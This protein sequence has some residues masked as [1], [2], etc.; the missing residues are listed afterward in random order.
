GS[1][2]NGFDVAGPVTIDRA[3]LSIAASQGASYPIVAVKEINRSGPRDPANVP[4]KAPPTAVNRQPANNGIRLALNVQAPQAVFVRG[5]GLDA[6]MGGS[7]QVTGA[8]A[9]PAVI[10]GLMIRRGDFT[11]GGRRLVFSRGIVSLNNVDRI[12]PALDFIAPTSV[13]STTI[14]VAIT[15]SAAAPAIAITSVPALPQD[16]ALAM[17]LFGKPASG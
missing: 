13:Q 8:P 6:E 1:S 4:A 15:G 5:R 9:A 10:G 12:D 11:L 2:L 16:E 7:F 14:N 17:L 3:E